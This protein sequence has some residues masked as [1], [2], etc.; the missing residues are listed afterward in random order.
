MFFSPLYLHCVCENKN[1]LYYTDS[2]RKMQHVSDDSI[3][4]GAGK[5]SAAA[6][7][8]R[9]VNVSVVFAKAYALRCF[10]FRCRMKY[11]A[12]CFEIAGSS[13]GFSGVFAAGKNTEQILRKPIFHHCLYNT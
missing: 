12:E 13:C 2:A 10:G 8:W 6:K 7:A 11:P 4:R 3:K 5:F 1:Y 9:N